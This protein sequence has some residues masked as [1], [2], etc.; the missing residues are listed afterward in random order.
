MNYSTKKSIKPSTSKCKT[1]QFCQVYYLYYAYLNNRSTET[2][3]QSCFF[4]QGQFK[5]MNEL[6]IFL[7]VVVMTMCGIYYQWVACYSP[8]VS[9][10]GHSVSQLRIGKLI[11]PS[12][13]KISISAMGIL[14]SMIVVKKKKDDGI[15]YW[16]SFHA[17]IAEIPNDIISS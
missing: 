15:F 7:V 10:N 13:G 16:P 12:I 1:L 4:K 11:K 3:S 14:F 6:S 5:L 8:F 2:N 9:N 17:I